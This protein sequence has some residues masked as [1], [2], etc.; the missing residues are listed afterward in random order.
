MIKGFVGQDG[1]LSVYNAKRGVIDPI[2]KSPKQVFFEWNRNTFNISG[3]ETDFVEGLFQFSESLFAP[4]YHKV[5]SQKGPINLEPIDLFHIIH[6]IGITNWRIPSRDE[7]VKRIIKYSTN[8][9][10]LFTIRNKETNQE[11]AAESYEWIMNQPAFIESSK[12][13]LAIRDYL[14]TDIAAHYESWKIYYSSTDVQLH[15][16]GDNPIIKRDQCN[17]NIFQTEIIFPL[18]KGKTIYHTNGKTIRVLPPEHR[19]KID[20]LM[21]LQADKMVC[22]PNGDYLYHLVQLANQYKT[23]QQIHNLKESIFSV[24]NE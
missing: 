18:S 3:V 12:L 7:E 8:K 10:L 17:P 13:I 24:F 9:D 16:L 14:M 5:V 4:V 21:I 11:A 6:F 20:V 15:L 2:R 23:E 19:A 22:S 1:K